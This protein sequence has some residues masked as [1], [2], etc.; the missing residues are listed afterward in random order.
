[1]IS[2]DVRSLAQGLTMGKEE[3]FSVRETIII[4]MIEAAV[5]IVNQPHR[6]NEIVEPLEYAY[7][8]EYEVPAPAGIISRFVAHIQSEMK[9]HGWDRRLIVKAEFKAIQ[10]SFHRANIVMDL[11]ATI[12]A[13]G[14]AI[15]EAQDKPEVLDVVSDNPDAET[16]NEL[17]KAIDRESQRRTP[18][19]SDRHAKC[20]RTPTNRNWGS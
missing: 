17:L 2:F 13:K 7:E 10:K 9:K 1:M 18:L 19:L 12:L 3:P 4:Q 16:I 20:V 6:L 15:Q 5:A 11:D 14:E 8:F